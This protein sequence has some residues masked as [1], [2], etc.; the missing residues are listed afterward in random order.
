MNEVNMKNA[1]AKSINQFDGEMIGIFETSAE[2]EYP[3]FIFWLDDFWE[4][5]I[6]PEHDVLS[7][8]EVEEELREAIKDGIDVDV[9][10]LKGAIEFDLTGND[11]ENDYAPTDRPGR[12]LG[13][14]AI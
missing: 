7:E 13:E 2:N 8:T 10:F 3:R 6:L 12:E 1:T 4:S 5:A 14:W 9:F 11:I